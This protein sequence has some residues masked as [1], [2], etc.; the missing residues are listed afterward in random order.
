MHALPLG[1]A[2]TILGIIFPPLYFFSGLHFSPGSSWH[3]V[4]KFC[5]GGFYQQKG[6]IFKIF[7]DSEIFSLTSDG[8]REKFEGVFADMFAKKNS[9]CLDGGRANHQVRADNE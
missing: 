9:A 1:I 7:W 4:T 3:R 8:F 5:I 2:G 6:G